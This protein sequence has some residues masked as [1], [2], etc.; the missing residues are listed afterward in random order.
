MCTLA[1]YFQEFESYP[2]TIVA[3][4]DEFLSRPSA[5][6]QVLVDKPLVFGGKD[7]LAG[8][9][10]LGVNEHGLLVG[11]VNRRSGADTERAKRRSRGLLCLDLLKAKDPIQ[12][13]EYLR[14]IKGSNY[15]P[16]NLLFANSMEAYAAYN[17]EERIECVGLKKG[18]HV[19][20]NSAIYG[21]PSGKI[22][23]AN[24]L[25]NDARQQIS[26]G[27]MNPSFFLRIF[28]R[29]LQIW[30]QPSLIRLFKGILGNHRLGDGS[31]DPKDAICVHTSSYGTVSSTVIFY[32]GYEKK[33]HYYH[34]SGSPC[35][36]EY[37]KFLSVEVR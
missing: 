30:D 34:S 21:G 15:Q 17:I 16:F 22:D 31:R 33:F 6:P 36:S 5:P 8:G 24:S 20:S 4:R 14:Q 23:Y 35:R 11:I 2:L 37:E 9:T 18:V 10:W 28:R 25:L 3:N 32:S 1:L 7:L 29:D 26:Q 19:L 27:I 12:A 13:V